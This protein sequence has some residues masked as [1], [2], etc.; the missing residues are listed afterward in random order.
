MKTNASVDTVKK[1]VEKVSKNLY[2]GNVIFRRE[3]QHITKNVVRFTLKTKDAEGLGSLVTKNGQKHPKANWQVHLDV[4]KEIF[5]L[6][7]KSNIYVDSIAGRLYS[8]NVPQ[9][10]EKV[11]DIPTEQVK[12]EDKETKK[13]LKAL[14][15][16]L[17]HKNVLE[18]FV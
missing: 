17:D 16:V 18:K 5:K 4:I 3:P 15:Y 6:E 7:P 14:K 2:E 10:E 8:D 9:E 1:A 12:E 11:E 13:F